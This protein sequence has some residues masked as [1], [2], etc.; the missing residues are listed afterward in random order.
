VH[1]DSKERERF[2]PEA[3]PIWRHYPTAELVES[4]VAAAHPADFSSLLSTAG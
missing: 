4:A 1:P 2:S 3:L